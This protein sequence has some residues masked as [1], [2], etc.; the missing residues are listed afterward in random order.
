MS[1]LDDELAGIRWCG[2]IRAGVRQI[3]DDR[4]IHALVAG[5]DVRGAGT[6]RESNSLRAWACQDDHGMS[7]ISRKRLQA[8]EPAVIDCLSSENKVRLTITTNNIDRQS[9]TQIRRG[10]INRSQGFRSCFCI[11]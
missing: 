1:R 10:S 11:Q 8:L 3:A 9:A 5:D 2:K 6:V 4:L 7:A